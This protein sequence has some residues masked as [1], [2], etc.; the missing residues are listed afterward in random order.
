VRTR[1]SPMRQAIDYMAVL[2]VLPLMLILSVLLSAGVESKLA[3]NFF[4]QWLPTFVIRSVGHVATF[5]F[6]AFGLWFLYFF[7]PNTR[8]PLRAALVGAIVAAIMW[9]VLQMIFIKLQLGLSKYNAI[10]GTLAAVPI[11]ML[12]L[13][14]SWTVI[15][16]G[17][18]VSY[19]YAHQSD[20]QFGGLAFRAGPAQREQIALGVAALAAQAFIQ[21]KDPPCCEELCLHARAPATVVREVLA[22][23]VA[24]RVLAEVQ[25]SRACY[26]PAAPPNQITLGRVIDAVNYRTPDL[27]HMSKAMERLGVRSALQQRDEQSAAFRNTTLKQLVLENAEKA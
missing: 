11:F 4:H 21:E 1:R 15:L 22:D 12:W 26:A 10:Y 3:I 25:G 7:F 23:L 8:I 27:P 5:G 2:F 19:S 17:A 9:A 14:L 18:E 16:F 20:Y 6:T 13:Q 24:A